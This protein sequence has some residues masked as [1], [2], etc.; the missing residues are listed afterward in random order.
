MQFLRLIQFLLW[1]C[2]CVTCHSVTLVGLLS[3]CLL[4]C[5]VT[6]G[7]SCDNTGVQ[8]SEWCGVTVRC[9]RGRGITNN[10]LVLDYRVMRTW[11]DDGHVEG[12]CSTLTL[13]HC[14]ALQDNI[15]KP[16]V[17]RSWFGQF[18][19]SILLVVRPEWEARGDTGDQPP[20]T[21]E[22]LEEVEVEEEEVLEVSWREWSLTC[23]TP[24]W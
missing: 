22:V 21:M 10:Q 23:W 4:K 15:Y 1:H 17:C 12:N 3:C 16:T 5:S 7:L 6:D 2:D 18:S 13:Q 20:L 14:S 9:T 19:A 8:E 11:W 24:S